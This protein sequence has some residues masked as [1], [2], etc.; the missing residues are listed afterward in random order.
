MS[1]FFFFRLETIYS[2]KNPYPKRN[3]ETINV[4]VNLYTKVGINTITRE[5]TW[6]GL[7]NPHRD[8]RLRPTYSMKE[9]AQV[10]FL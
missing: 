2:V 5:S 9:D 6:I 4:K 1:D 7:K 8:Y 3:N 10:N